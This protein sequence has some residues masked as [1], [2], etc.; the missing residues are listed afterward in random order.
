MSKQGWSG[1]LQCDVNGNGN[2]NGNGA[3][4]KPH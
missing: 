4:I 2:T 3:T 1:R